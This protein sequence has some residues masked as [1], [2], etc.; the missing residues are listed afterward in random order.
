MSRSLKF[1]AWDDYNKVMKCY[2]LK[3]LADEDKFGYETEHEV[4]QSG[5]DNWK[6]SQF[7]GLKDRA[8]KEIYEGDFIM[9]PNHCGLGQVEF[10]TDF[11]GCWVVKEHGQ[12]NRGAQLLGVI[13]ESDIEVVGNIY[14]NPEIAELK[15]GSI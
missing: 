3:E 4:I 5:F 11:N 15:M 9:A 14:E 7:T 1:R 8:G 6:W 12:P 13:D 2:T 10:G